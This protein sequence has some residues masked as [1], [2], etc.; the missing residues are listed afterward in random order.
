[1]KIFVLSNDLES[2]KEI[3]GLISK[4]KKAK[5]VGFSSDLTE[6]ILSIDSPNEADI[7]FIDKDLDDKE[8]IK[9]NNFFKP[10]FRC[11]FVHQSGDTKTHFFK[12]NNQIEHITK[13]YHFQSFIDILSRNQFD[14]PANSNNEVIS[15]YNDH[16]FIKCDKGKIRKIDVAD[17]IYVEASQNYIAIFQLNGSYLTNFTLN[18]IE[19]VLPSDIFIRVH[20][21]FIINFNKIRA[22]ESNRI[23]F[24]QN[25][26]VPVGHS[27]RKQV[28]NLFNSKMLDMSRIA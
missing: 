18:G 23:V 24:D 22:I 21:S 4:S 12:K 2:G 6:L 7:V 28:L 17:I 14:E 19:K 16:F 5:C 25:I 3:I 13:P 15:G 20:R 10:S 26:Y 1:M 8:I 9:L 27:Y 11:V